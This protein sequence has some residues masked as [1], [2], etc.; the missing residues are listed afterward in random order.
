MEI[1]RRD[2]AGGDLAD[3]RARGVRARDALKGNLEGVAP[4]P[5]AIKF[6][7]PVKIVIKDAGREDKDGNSYLAYFF[8]PA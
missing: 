8:Q 7:M 6:D 4:V 1:V 2:P 3:F 5:D